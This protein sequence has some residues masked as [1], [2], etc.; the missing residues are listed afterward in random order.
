MRR[1]EHGWVGGIGGLKGRKGE[2]RRGGGVTRNRE[3]QRCEAENE[4]MRCGSQI[5]KV[6]WVSDG[7]SGVGLRSRKWCGSQTEKVV[8]VSD[9][10]SGG[11]TA[12]RGG[13]AT[14]K[15]KGEKAQCS[16]SAR[17]LLEARVFD[18]HTQLLRAV[19]LPRMLL[20]CRPRNLEG[21]K[22]AG[23]GL[24]LMHLRSGKRFGPETADFARFGQ[25]WQTRAEI[26]TLDAAKTTNQA[27]QH[28]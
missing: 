12:G 5:E 4:G 20:A 3:K 21:H 27:D 19:G 8:W 18:R 25:E 24:P 23:L 26:S 1:A 22:A 10:E 7:E 11:S 14:R 2:T 17:T 15:S 9:G 16:C 28:A 6:V 13:R